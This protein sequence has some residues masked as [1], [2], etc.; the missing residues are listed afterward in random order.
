MNGEIDMDNWILIR[1]Y[2]TFEGLTIRGYKCKYC[3]RPV[4]ASIPEEEKWDTNILSYNYCPH[5]GK[6]I[7]ENRTIHSENRTIHS[8]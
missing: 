3:D 8:E 6:M 7:N 5:C 1:E 2:P 4:L